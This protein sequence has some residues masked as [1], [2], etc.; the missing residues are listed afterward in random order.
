MNRKLGRISRFTIKGKTNRIGRKVRE[1][2]ISLGYKRLFESTTKVITD[3]NEKLVKESIY[4]T[5][6]IEKLN[7]SK[8][9]L[10]VSQL[11]NKN[12]VVDTSL[13][14]HL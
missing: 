9:H 2:G 7:E 5:E 12:G 10:E 4:T 6:A 3:T 14:R 8:L 11:I 1:T 13:L